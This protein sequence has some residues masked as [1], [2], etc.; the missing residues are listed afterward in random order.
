MTCAVTLPCRW[1]FCISGWHCFCMYHLLL[2]TMAARYYTRSTNTVNTLRLETVMCTCL[3]WHRY[4]VITHRIGE[5]TRWLPARLYKN[6]ES[7][8][9]FPRA[10]RDRPVGAPLPQPWSQHSYHGITQA[11]VCS[12]HGEKT[13]MLESILWRRHRARSASVL[14]NS[15]ESSQ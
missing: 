13:S 5:G 3:P 7:T 2:W 9:L 14:G 6:W 10:E 1:W 12:E 11:G 15:G 8:S 4:N